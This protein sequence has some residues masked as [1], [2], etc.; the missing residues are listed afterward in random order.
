MITDQLCVFFDDAAATA[1][2]TGSPVDV[3]LYSGRNEPVYISILSKGGGGPMDIAATLE[4]SADGTAFTAVGT[5]TFKRPDAMPAIF[6]MQLPLATNKPII[7]LKL[8]L[9]GTVGGT[10]F[11]GVTRDHYAPYANGQYIDHGKVVK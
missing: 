6:V 5:S 11:A 3:S 8:A 4:E 2:M 7:R 10:V 9:S 1:S